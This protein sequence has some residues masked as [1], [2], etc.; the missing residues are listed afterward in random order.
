M[1]SR[2]FIDRPIFAAV[3]SIVL[4]GFGGECRTVDYITPW[5]RSVVAW[6]GVLGQA[7]LFLVVNTVAT[8]HL[9][10]RAFTG[11]DTYFAVT[12]ANVLIAVFNLLP[13]RGLDGSQAWRL[14]WLSY[15]RAK[16]AWMMWRLARLKGSSRR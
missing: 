10:P 3:L 5:Q 11:S 16:R 8:L 13:L 2:F 7:A 4:H 15:L 6:G 9:W 12:G 1:F 14:L